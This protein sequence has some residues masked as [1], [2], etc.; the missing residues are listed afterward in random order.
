MYDISVYLYLDLSDT[1]D[2]EE[3]KRGRKWIIRRKCCFRL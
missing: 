2:P 1:V 3:Q